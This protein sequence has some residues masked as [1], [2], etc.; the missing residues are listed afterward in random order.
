[1]GSL[2]RYVE[3]LAGQHVGGADAA[4]DHGGAGTVDTGVRTLGTAQAELHDAVALGCVNDAG[5][6]GGDQALVVDDVQDGGLHQLRLHD[7]RDDLDQRLPG[8]DDGSFGN[9][10]DVAA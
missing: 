3:H 7:G 4:A 1:M 9:G 6:L 10:V 5:R 8:E 2:D